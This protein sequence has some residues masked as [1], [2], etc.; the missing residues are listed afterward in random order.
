MSDQITAVINVGLKWI[1]LSTAN[2]YLQKIN[3]IIVAQ[4]AVTALVDM[5]ELTALSANYTL[6]W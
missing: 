2:S 4:P 5:T 3:N 1:K 6:P